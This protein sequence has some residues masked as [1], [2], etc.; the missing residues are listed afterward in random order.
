M[1]SVCVG[2]HA[3]VKL[4]LIGLL[5]ATLY[6]CVSETFNLG[7]AAFTLLRLLSNMQ[8]DMWL[9]DKLWYFRAIASQF[10]STLLPRFLT[11]AR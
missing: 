1:Y 5:D 10:Y 8:R 2:C 4:I 6:V 11:D 3:C 9:L 7:L